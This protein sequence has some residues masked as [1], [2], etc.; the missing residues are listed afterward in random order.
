MS[1]TG[2]VYELPAGT[3]DIGDRHT[4]GVRD[5]SLIDQ[6]VGQRIQSLRQMRHISQEQLGKALGLTFQQIQKYERGINRISASRLFMVAHFLG[7]PVSFF[8]EGLPSGGQLW[9][10]LG[11]H[12]AEDDAPPY[13]AE[14]AMTKETQDV[15]AAFARITDPDMRR[16]M[17]R[18]VADVAAL[19]GSDDSEGNSDGDDADDNSRPVANTSG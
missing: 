19:Y 3:A 9:N 16:N 10:W 18:L 5:A 12:L 1:D 2:T 11:G 8:F 7:V 13:I 15:L 14:P 4:K 17:I 6:Y